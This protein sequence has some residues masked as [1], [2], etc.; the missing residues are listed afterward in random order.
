MFASNLGELYKP[1]DVARKL[2]VSRRTVYQWLT[3]KRLIGLKVGHGWR[4]TESAL[5]GFLKDQRKEAERG[6]P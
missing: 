1:E 5:S 4:V 3:N 2:R 6:G